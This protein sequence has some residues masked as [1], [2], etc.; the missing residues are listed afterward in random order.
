MLSNPNPHG[1]KHF[2]WNKSTIWKDVF[3]S[4]QEIERPSTS[5]WT[6]MEKNI[7]IELYD[8]HKE[9]LFY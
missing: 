3:K 5:T 7:N 9:P 2:L 1:T 4:D 8:K 6:V